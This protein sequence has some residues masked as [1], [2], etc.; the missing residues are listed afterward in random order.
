MHSPVALS[1]SCPYTIL[2]IEQL[3]VTDKLVLIAQVFAK[4]AYN[5]WP[6]LVVAALVVLFVVRV[7]KRTR[8][9]N[10]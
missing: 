8:R 7:E 6:I 3:T 9:R 4:I 1:T 5:F 10:W 2:M